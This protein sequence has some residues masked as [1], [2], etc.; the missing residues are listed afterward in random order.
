MIVPRLRGAGVDQELIEQKHRS[1]KD[2][3]AI[4][5]RTMEVLLIKETAACF[6][7]SSCFSA[8]VS[9]FIVGQVYIFVELMSKLPHPSH[10]GWKRRG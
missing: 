10:D 8:G 6:D 2:A 5:K 1:M 9:G 4:E 7:F 3:V